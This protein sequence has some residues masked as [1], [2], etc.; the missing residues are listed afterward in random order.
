MKTFQFQAVS[1]QV[2]GDLHTLVSLYLKVRDLYPESVLLESSDFH[3]SENSVS[4]IGICP[5]A[6]FG[7]NSGCCT[8]KYPDRT[9]EKIPVHDGTDISHALMQFLGTLKVEGAGAKSCGLFGYTSFNAVRYFEHIEIKDTHADENDAPE[10]LYTF[11]KYI[12]MLDHFKNTLTLIELLAE[13]EDS[14]IEN[15]L[16]ILGNT[17]F[18]CYNFRQVGEETSNVTDEEYMDYVREGIRHCQRGDVFQIVLSRRFIQKYEGDDFKVYRALRSINPSPYLFYFDFGGFRIFGSSPETH[19]KIEGGRACIDPIAGTYRRTGNEEED[20]KA[21]ER[22]L[23]DPK[24]NAEHTMLVDLARNDLSRNCEQVHVD[25][26]KEPQFY[27]HVIHLVSRV[28]GK[29]KENGANPVQVFT[30]TFPA[31]TLSGAPKVRAMQLIS[32]IENVSRGA[33]G[34]CIGFIGLDGSLNQ[35]I[36]IRSFVSR[37]GELWYQAGAGIVAKSR[38]EDELQEVNNK[39]G[40][41]KRAIEVAAQLKN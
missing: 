13:G 27:S 26:Y 16:T 36:T 15:L 11:Y 25:F 9:E 31:G 22:L 23:R 32:E 8:L 5:L 20:R 14:Q 12:L 4:Y 34:G 1:R 29:L 35:A 39:L 33:Y 38:P 18:P 10:M 19:C 24:E 40:A 21:A 2:L 6:S 17:N 3:S 30:D 28:S 7:V 41:L 37:N